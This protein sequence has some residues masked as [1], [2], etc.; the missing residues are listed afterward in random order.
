[1]QSLDT[2][3][4]FPAHWWEKPWWSALSRVPTH[5]FNFSCDLMLCFT[6]SPSQLLL[7]LE[8]LECLVLL[9]I[10][11]TVFSLIIYN[12]KVRALLPRRTRVGCGQFHHAEILST[13][14]FSV[15]RILHFCRWNTN[16]MKFPSPCFV[17]L[18]NLGDPYLLAWIHWLYSGISVN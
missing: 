11:L 1:M 7:K 10:Y 6:D 4:W 16:F 12:Q 2:V 8:Q 17:S 15:L 18:Q 5:R 3:S 14:S 13:Q 9:L